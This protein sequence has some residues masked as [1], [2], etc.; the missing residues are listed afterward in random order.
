MQRGMPDLSTPPQ[1]VLEPV[2]WILETIEAQLSKSVFSH[3]K[4]EEYDLNT[5]TLLQVRAIIKRS[6]SK[7]SCVGASKILSAL[8][9]RLRMTYGL[10]L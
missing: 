9:R 2:E 5:S 7:S 4:G 6:V 3:Q 10:N 1:N 8:S